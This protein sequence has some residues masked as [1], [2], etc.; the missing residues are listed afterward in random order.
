[1]CYNDK[2]SVITGGTSGIG[3]GCVRVFVAAGSKVVLCAPKEH[4]G[5]A[6]AAELTRAGPGSAT[7]IR[8]DVRKPA[9]IQN[10]IDQTVKL[11]GRIDCLINNAGWHPPSKTID[12][13]SIQD[14]QDQFQLNLIIVY[15]PPTFALPH[16]RKSKGKIIN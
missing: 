6:F 16:L 4:E 14:F 3:A 15:A 12:E 8:C 9:E 1:M 13:F 2:V 11:H 5:D 7:F 10:L